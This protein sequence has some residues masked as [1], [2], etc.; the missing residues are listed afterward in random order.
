MPANTRATFTKVCEACGITFQRKRYGD[1]R[2]ENSV[3]WRARRACSQPCG[4]ELRKRTYAQRREAHQHP[5]C[6]ICD[7]PVVRRSTE[8][9]Q[10]WRVRKTCSATCRRAAMGRGK[11]PRS[12]PRVLKQR[13]SPAREGHVFD[14][15]FPT[16]RGVTSWQSVSGP[17]TGVIATTP[18]NGVPRSAQTVAMLR[19]A[20]RAHPDLGNALLG[21]LSDS[22][23]QQDAATYHA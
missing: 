8:S 18:H 9:S 22:W 5:P 6:P 21:A 3:A 2:L 10:R 20:V 14:G 23:V 12:A 15:R 7:G 13:V 17:D 19:A 11:E 1:D 16:P 4:N